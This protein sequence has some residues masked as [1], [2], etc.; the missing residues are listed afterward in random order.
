[1]KLYGIRVF[2]RDLAAARDF[3]GG[4]LGLPEAWASDEAIG[5]DI[6]AALI[7][8]VET[9]EDPKLVGR[10][11]GLSLEV[12]DIVS[13]QA[14]LAAAGVPFTGPPERQPW[15]GRLTHLRD[16]DGNILSLVELP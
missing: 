7:V 13:A 12:S 1:M 2:V 3:Y 8:E 6:G 9:G 15:G 10:F 16:P 5:Y 4:A 14:A 11:T